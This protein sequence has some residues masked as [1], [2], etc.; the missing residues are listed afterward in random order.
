MLKE[1]N[2][3]IIR[4]IIKR[5][6]IY[7]IYKYM[8]LLIIC[9]FSLNSFA[10][11]KRSDTKES[12]NFVNKD[13]FKNSKIIYDNDSTSNTKLSCI[14]YIVQEDEN[15]ISILRK[16]NYYPIYG[17]NGYLEK[18]IQL[19]PKTNRQNEVLPPGTNIC[20]VE[21]ENDNNKELF[22]ENSLQAFYLEG[23][24]KYLR[25]IEKDSIS[26]TSAKLLSRPIAMIEAGL[27][28]KWRY[29]FKSYL[30]I[31]YSISEI[32]QSDSS[33]VIGDNIIR[34]TNYFAGL[35]YKFN[36]IFYTD[37][38]ISYGDILVV[39]AISDHVLK[40][41]KMSNTKL[42][43]LG[44]IKFLELDAF[45]FNT[46][47]GLLLNSKFENEIYNADYG[48]GYE[49]AIIVAYPNKGWELRSRL[50]YSHYTTNVQPVEFDY[51]EIGLMLRL[52]VDLE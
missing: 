18:T 37:F 30:G 5:K 49:G 3:E 44:G 17:K 7:C 25:L 4:N 10:T 51:T 43:L 21:K 14:K 33:V 22:V 6:A 2:M 42:K 47:I 20:L 11:E 29:D 9:F 8:H 35:N 27:E 52:T 38:L 19:N 39:R 28:Q 24:I 1:I 32:M 46:E 36:N 16:Q 41:E 13:E 26:G 40:I 23:G 34:L 31:N 15:L 45:I 12:Q 48:K 50:F